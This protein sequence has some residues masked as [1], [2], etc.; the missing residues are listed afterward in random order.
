MKYIDV[1][2]FDMIAAHLDGT[3]P[4]KTLVFNA[5]NDGVVFL[6]KSKFEC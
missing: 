5:A 1:V 3:F 2:S 4:G 6:R